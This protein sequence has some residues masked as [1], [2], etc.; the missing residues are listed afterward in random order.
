M[1]APAPIHS[2]RIGTVRR[3]PGA[4]L[5]LVERIE[6]G[7]ENVIGEDAAN[8]GNRQFDHDPEA[9]EVGRGTGRVRL[10][11]HELALEGVEQRQDRGVMNRIML[12][13]VRADRPREGHRTAEVATPR[14]GLRRARAHDRSNVV[15]G[16]PHQ[17]FGPFHDLVPGFLNGPEQLLE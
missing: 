14:P 10:G 12:R 16:T 3:E 5:V 4:E 17:A 6:A 11:V 7:F 8:G 13:R 15:N 9:A 1:A 2:Y